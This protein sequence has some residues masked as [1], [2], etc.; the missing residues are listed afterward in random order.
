MLRCNTISVF[1]FTLPGAEEW[2]MARIPV[3]KA[4]P[5]NK[6]FGQYGPPRHGPARPLPDVTHPEASRQLDM[7]PKGM[8]NYRRCRI[9]A[10][11]EASDF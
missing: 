8:G 3:V 7:W 11:F 4:T 9:A 1:L 6:R 5:N 2:R 10:R